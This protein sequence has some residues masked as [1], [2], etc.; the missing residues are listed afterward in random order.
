M[1]AMKRIIY[2]LSAIVITLAGAF[3]CRHEEIV[4]Q[5]ELSITDAS[6]EQVLL[7]GQSLEYPLELG[8]Y[9]YSNTKDDANEIVK[10]D[11]FKVKSNCSWRLVPLGETPDWI[12]PFPDCG[13]KDGVFIFVLN[14]NNDQTNSRTAIWQVVLNDGVNDIQVGGNIIVTQSAAVDF[15]KVSKAQLDV[16]KEGATASFNVVTNLPWTYT[17][18]P[19]ED[20][21]SPEIETWIED[22]SNITE[23]A[24]TNKLSFK[25]ADNSNGSI[26]AA[27]IVITPEGHP[28][29]KKEVVLTQYGLDIEMDGLPVKWKAASN[30]Y[31]NWPSASNAVPTVNASEGKG[32]I[33]LVRAVVDGI[34]RTNSTADI[35]GSNPR[36]NGVWPGDY[37]EFNVPV[38]ISAGS[39]VKIQ[40]ECRVSAQGVR[41][42]RLEYKDGTEWKVAATP[43]IAEIPA[44]D[45]WPAETITYT[46]SLAPGGSDDTGNK[47]ITQV[48]RYANTSDE[49]AFRF[50]AASNVRASQDTRMANPTTAS[51]R[52]DFSGSA[53]GCEPEISCVASGGEL[54]LADIQVN[55]LDRDFILFEGK[56][57]APVTFSVLS[58]EDFTVTPSVDW[59]H[60]TEGATGPADEE[61]TVAITCDESNLSKIREATVTVQAGVTRKVI[62]VIQSA[63]GQ[64][65]DPFISLSSGNTAS[66]PAQEGSSQVR[67]QANIDVEAESDAA[68]ITVAKAPSS[69]AMVE[70]TD[71]SLS[72]EANP[73][74]SPRVAHVRFFNTGEGQEAVLT[75]T[76]EARPSGT[77]Y[78]SDDFEWLKPYIDAYIKAV[79][80]DADKLDPVGSNLASHAQPN[81]WN[82]EDL[83]ATVGAD[84]EGRG[85]EDLNKAAKTLYMQKNYFKM[86]ATD[87]HTGLRLPKMDFEG[88]TPVDVVLSFDWCAHM[89]GKGK[90]D[91]VTLTVELSGDGVCSDTGG[92]LSGEI[93]TTQVANTLAWQH[94]SV[95]LKGVTSSTRI[96]IRPTHMSDGAG[97]NQQRWHLDNIRVE[98]APEPLHAEWLFSADAMSAYASTFGGTTAVNVKEAGD[99]GLYVNS[100]VTKGGRI[101]Y[102]QVDK[103]AID[104]D[105]KAARLVGASGHPYVTGAWPGDYWL[106]EASDGTE[107]PAGTKVHIMFYTRLS[108]TGHKYWMLE[109]YDGA[110]WKPVSEV[111]E[112]SVTAPNGDPVTVSYNFEPTT[113]SATNSLVD[114]TWTL[115][116]PCGN[117]Q[118]RY[119]CMS[120]WQYNGKGALAAPNGGTCRIAGAAGT[121]PVFEVVD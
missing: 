97:A 96:V 67:V 68:W 105:G 16:V 88:S 112:V 54:K 121:S 50:I 33:T 118:F 108:A 120:N 55:G 6:D 95:K 26:R 78:F 79:P 17:L 41:H 111:K 90:I 64:E 109:Y 14:R 65:L 4:Q 10:A 31:P 9:Q 7:Y 20:Y 104:T 77:V 46:H 13:D 101:R 38:P 57:E 83:A 11:I 85:Y 72:Y 60:V 43:L 3:S 2:Y 44:D 71:F 102:F 30:D 36:I 113:D 12:R 45:K 59:L 47:V 48:V 63:A 92:K 93:A 114:F 75:V 119:T 74:E 61:T 35:N 116:A 76:Q 53:T 89:T 66:I 70:W 1:K 42:W 22:R 117:M 25:V 94:A 84:L 107:Y 40:F 62:T 98:K 115:A 34:D 82:T 24:I 49:V 100:N 32:T 21:A 8:Y 5:P 99:G 106:F 87:K 37:L 103:T 18:V 29:L 23:G 15:L 39:L 58:S 28:D 52:L 91:A 56:P 69:H 110:G 86:G 27:T 19:V 51:A 81:I 73:E 80:A